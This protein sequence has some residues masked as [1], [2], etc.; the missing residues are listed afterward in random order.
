MRKCFEMKNVTAINFCHFF[1]FFFSL[2]DSFITF[3][4]TFCKKAFDTLIRSRV[5]ATDVHA[6]VTSGSSRLFLGNFQ[7]RLK[8]RIRISLARI[9]F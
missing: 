8:Y 9:C 1:V 3:Y 5:I 2:F 6:H 7:P 4:L